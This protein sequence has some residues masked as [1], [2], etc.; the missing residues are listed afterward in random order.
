MNPVSGALI[1]RYNRLGRVEWCLPK[2]HLEGDE[3]P[4]EAA[5]REIGEETGIEAEIVDELG[6]INYWFAVSGRKIHKRVHH[7]L[8]FAR[9]GELSVAGD[10]DGE[11]F[12]AAWV[13]LDELANRLVYPNER[14]IAQSARARLAVEGN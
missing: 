1:A 6:V 3:T 7:F 13:P 12:D 2:G 9:G 4:A 11:A 5:V 14:K 10:P 8:M